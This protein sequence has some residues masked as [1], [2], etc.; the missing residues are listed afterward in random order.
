MVVNEVRPISD[1]RSTADYRLRVTANVVEQFLLWT[2]FHACCGS[3]RWADAMADGSQDPW[4]NLEEKD[5]LEAFAAHPKIGE[6]PPNDTTAAQE[7]KSIGS[8][9]P[10]ILASLAEGNRRYFEKFGYIYI[11]C[12]TGKSSE[13]M[14]TMLRERLD[15]DAAQEIRIAADEQRKI[16]ALRLEKFSA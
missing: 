15:N 5:W 11:V 9:S 1:I 6:K 4:W 7:Q 3:G 12:A 8:A 13:E 10:E 16:T 14:L 2:K